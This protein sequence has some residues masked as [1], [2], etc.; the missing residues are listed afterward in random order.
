L[1]EKMNKA[2]SAGHKLGQLIGN[3]FEGVLLRHLQA[4]ATRKGLFLDCK[5]PRPNVRGKKHG[6]TWR[7]RRNNAHDMDYVLER[8]GSTD[9]LGQPVAFIEVAWRR[10]T[11]HSRN[12]TGEIE[13]AL[14]HLRDSYR[15]CCFIGAILAGEYTDGGI[16][17][18]KS[19][20]ITVL[21][22][23][24]RVLIESFRTMNVDLDYPENAPANQKRRLIKYPGL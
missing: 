21:H 3:F 6:V 13:G 5:G 8:N 24:Y 23:P 11:K 17:Q 18:L 9:K 2:T 15:S 4:L 22:V 12:K 14:L 7:D 19:H 10:Y 1:G 20:G 16:Q